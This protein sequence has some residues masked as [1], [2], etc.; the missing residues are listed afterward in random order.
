MTRVSGERPSKSTSARRLDRRSGAGDTAMP[1]KQCYLPCCGVAALVHFG[2]RRRPR[3]PQ[4]LIAAS[5]GVSVPRASVFPATNLARR[6][7]AER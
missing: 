1:S 2:E 6:E 7:V 5:G 3:N 4:L